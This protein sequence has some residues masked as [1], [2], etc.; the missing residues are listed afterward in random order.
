MDSRT[1]TLTMASATDAQKEVVKRYKTEAA[2]GINCSQNVLDTL[3]IIRR[4]L[5]FHKST[6]VP[7]L[8]ARETAGRD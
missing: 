6:P 7:C 1:K 8:D 4:K 2:D 5:H 3:S